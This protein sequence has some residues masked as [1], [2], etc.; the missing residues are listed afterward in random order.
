[1]DGVVDRTRT[2]RQSTRNHGRG[3]RGCL[4]GAP[5]HDIACPT[6]SG[7]CRLEKGVVECEG[8]FCSS[9]RRGRR[10][11]ME[12][13][14]EK[15]QEGEAVMTLVLEWDVWLTSQVVSRWMISREEGGEEGTSE[16][17]E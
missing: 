2:S 5:A 11:A 13:Q 4:I 9:F 7:L 14:G 6:R 1:M 3:C 17:N 10:T 12:E 8:H 15:W 16:D